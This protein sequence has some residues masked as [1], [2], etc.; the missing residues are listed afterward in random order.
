MHALRAPAHARAPLPTNRRSARLA[1]ARAPAS[2]P[3]T[4]SAS[5]AS[6]AADLDARAQQLLALR[7]Q[8]RP[9]DPN[10]AAVAAAADKLERR[11][12]ELGR[13]LTPPRDHVQG[14][15]QG[16]TLTGRNVKATSGDLPLGALAFNAYQPA[17]TIVRIVGGGDA[18]SRILRG[19]ERFG[20]GPESYVL[21]TVFDVVS[22][23]PSEASEGAA[24]GAASSPQGPLL[25]GVS[26]AVARG[27]WSGGDDHPNRMDLQFA[28]M[29]L[30]PAPGTDLKRWLEAFAEANPGMD[31][32]TGRLTV[33]LPE[34][35]GPKGWID[36]LATTQRHTLIRGNFGSV[37]LLVRVEE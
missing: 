1:P 14:V 7:A 32:G 34:G 11:A 30:E 9:D 31:R 29:V 21:S 28:A 27:S 16:H 3:T 23:P 8:S 17:A 13:C 10:D 25:R 19:G 6:A 15:F 26:H 33:P 12:Q 20:V 4:T 18:P 5:A 24:A 2:S 35:K 36:H 22:M 37:S